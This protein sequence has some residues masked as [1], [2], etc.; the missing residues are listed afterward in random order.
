MYARTYHED[1]DQPSETLGHRLKLLRKS[2]AWSQQDVADRVGVRVLAVGK[3]ERDQTNPSDENLVA[4]AKVYGLDPRE[5]GY[6]PPAWTPDT[7]P[8][9]AEQYQAEIL[10]RIAALEQLLRDECEHVR[11]ME[12]SIT[13]HLRKA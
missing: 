12:K 8:L 4:L 2:R 10:A 5:L 7:P 6:E 1:M 13:N 3:W 11:V 9:W